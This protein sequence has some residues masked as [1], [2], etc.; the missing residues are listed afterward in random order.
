M[1]T[2][3][4]V[5]EYRSK[6]CVSGLGAWTQGLL[7]RCVLHP[8]ALTMNDSVRLLPRGSAPPLLAHRS[9]ACVLHNLALF[10]F[11]E[12]LAPYVPVPV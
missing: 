8:N 10:E 9:R 12:C 6:V 4:P 11:F 3:Y 1:D 5:R 7:A 2:Y